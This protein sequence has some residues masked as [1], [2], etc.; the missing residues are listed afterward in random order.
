M[1]KNILDK[2]PLRKSIK[3]LVWK[4]KLKL[5][6]SWISDNPPL[7]NQNIL[8]IEFLLKCVGC[9][10]LYNEIKKGFLPKSSCMSQCYQSTNFQYQAFCYLLR[11]P[12]IFFEVMLGQLMTS[13]TSEFISRD[14]LQE[15]LT[16][17]EEGER[18]IQ[19]LKIFKKRRGF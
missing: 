11:Y 7:K 15:W 8:F 19:K 16:G 14:F 4:K 3:G 10:R 17:K 18:G 5:C 6:F 13:W 12:G 9:F 1:S 2:V